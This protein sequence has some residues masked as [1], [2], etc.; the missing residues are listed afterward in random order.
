MHIAK[1]RG[2]SDMKMTAG[3]LPLVYSQTPEKGIL[4][5]HTDG[6]D[7]TKGIMHAMTEGQIQNCTISAE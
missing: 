6:C 7:T 1:G 2:G 3:I 4:A 5:Q